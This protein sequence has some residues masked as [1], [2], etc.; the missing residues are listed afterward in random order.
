MFWKIMGG[1]AAFVMVMVI[2]VTM[3][4]VAGVAVAG[5]AVSAIVESVDIGTVQVTDANGNTEIVDVDSLL[6]ES[7]RLEVLGNNGERVTIDV[8]V[9]QITVQEGGEHGSRVVI[10]GESGFEID[11]D[12]PQVRI[13]GRSFDSYAGPSIGRIIGGFFRG[14]INLA[15]LV[16]ITI[17]VWMVVR[18]NRRTEV[19]EK[20]LDAAA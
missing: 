13:D 10:G 1:I 20:S 3:L 2:A 16:V 18:N 15:L 6:S 11:S 9:P 5:T 7:G 12:V 14:M 19:V 8:N 4:A 17:G